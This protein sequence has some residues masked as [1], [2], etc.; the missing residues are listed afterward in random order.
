MASQ[1]IGEMNGA[2]SLLAKLAL[3]S[4]VPVILALGS[5]GWWVSAELIAMAANRWTSKDQTAYM[6]HHN[7]IHSDLPPDFVEEGIAT[8]R[9]GISRLENFHLK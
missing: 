8:N 7:Q 2:W 4:Y 3:A 6:Q 5:W 9:A 1:P